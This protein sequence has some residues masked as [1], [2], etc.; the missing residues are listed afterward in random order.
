MLKKIYF[1]FLTIKMKRLIERE[2]KIGDG[3]L[4][5]SIPE[6]LTERELKKLPTL[7]AVLELLKKHWETGKGKFDENAGQKAHK[8]GNL[9]QISMSLLEI[10]QDG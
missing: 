7:N 9:L 8:V 5:K 6:G 3:K 1:F 4:F 2:V 10:Y